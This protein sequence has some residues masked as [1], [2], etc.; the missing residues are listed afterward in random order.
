MPHRAASSTT[1]LHW[2]ALASVESE[3]ASFLRVGGGTPYLIV[4]SRVVETAAH[5]AQVGRWA[6]A[7]LAAGT[8]HASL[9]ESALD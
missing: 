1:S 7:L 4:N 3:A 2:H 8:L 6:D 5:H 9:P